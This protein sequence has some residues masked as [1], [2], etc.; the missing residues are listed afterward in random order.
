MFHVRNRGYQT[1]WTFL[2]IKFN[3][4]P[5]TNFRKLV[6]NHVRNCGKDDRSD[7]MECESQFDANYDM[8]KNKI[9]EDDV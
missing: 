2:Q 6:C 1:Q 4:N 9:K 8:N 3:L 5:E 7:E